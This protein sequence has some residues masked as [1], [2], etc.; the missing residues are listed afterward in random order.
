MA[1]ITPSLDVTGLLLVVHRLEVD[2]RADCEG[3]GP[4]HVVEHVTW[5]DEP[6]S[7]VTLGELLARVHYD[8]GDRVEVRWPTVAEERVRLMQAID[9]ARKH[10]LAR[11][12]D[13]L[14]KL[15]PP[16]PAAV[17]TWTDAARPAARRDAHGQL[18]ADPDGDT[19]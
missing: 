16:P 5:L 7:H 3:H 14:T 4:T 18:V 17:H 8:E 12:A 2:P 1:H 9:D 15:L 10:G 11:S 6:D 19:R 13:L